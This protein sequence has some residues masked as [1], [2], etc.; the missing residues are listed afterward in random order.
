[1]SSKSE[2]SPAAEKLSDNIFANVEHGEGRFDASIDV[3]S[4]GAPSDDTTEIVVTI[5]PMEVTVGI[6][7]EQSRE[8]RESLK[9]NEQGDRR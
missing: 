9:E 6:T 8:L 1:M 7:P 4:Y 2:D 5:G 3:R